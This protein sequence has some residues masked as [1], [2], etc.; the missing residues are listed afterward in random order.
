MIQGITSYA[1]RR[2]RGIS[3]I[4]YLMVIY[5]RDLPEGSN[6]QDNSPL[7]FGLA[8]GGV[9]RAPHIAMGSGVLLP[10]RFTIACVFNKTIGRLLSVAL[11]IASRRLR[12]TKHPVLWCPDF[13]LR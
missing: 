8:P 13:P 4:L 6:E 3:R 12:V 10:H 7:L 2:E 9:Y 5:L 11:S 1:M